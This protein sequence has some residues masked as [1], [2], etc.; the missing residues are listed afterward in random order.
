M[1]TTVFRD[2][3]LGANGLDRLAGATGGTVV[4][5]TEPRLNMLLTSAVGNVRQVPS[6]ALR[7]MR[8]IVQ[9]KRELFRSR[10]NAAA[11]RCGAGRSSSSPLASKVGDA[12]IFGTR[13]LSLAAR[14]SG[15]G[16]RSPLGPGR[17]RDRPVSPDPCGPCQGAR[18]VA[19]S[20]GS[21]GRTR[22]KVRCDR[23]VPPLA[24]GPCRFDRALDDRTWEDLNL[25]AVFSALDRTESTAGQHALYHRLRTTPVGPHLDAFDALATR[26]TADRLCGSA[27]SV[28]CRDWPTLTA[29]ISGGLA[30]RRDRARRRGTSLFPLLTA[31]VVVQAAVAAF[32]PEFVPGLIGLL[33]LNVAVR[34]GTDATSANCRRRSG[35]SHR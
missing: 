5:C 12:F 6:L 2:G 10:S 1:R 4:R 30:A 9:E 15:D 24:R 32:R 17:G 13:W 8:P 31:T 29:T 21:A 7:Q 14:V 11:S 19:E 35:R 25:D 3:D 18:A 20:V 34:Y 28:P 22:S 26:I 23:G 16:L 27:R 33:L